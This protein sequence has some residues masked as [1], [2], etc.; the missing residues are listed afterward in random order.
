M[1]DRVSLSQAV[2]MLAG[3]GD[4]VGLPSLSRYVKAHADALDA[5]TEG[6]KILVDFETL[7]RHRAENVFR[8][9]PSPPAPVVSDVGTASRSEEAAG[10]L[11]AQRRLRELELAER[12]K[13]LTPRREV[14]EAA[15]VAVSALKNAFSL[16]LAETAETI[17]AAVGCEARLI[18]PHLRSFERKGLEAFIRTLID[19]GLTTEEEAAAS[20]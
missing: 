15:V 1:Q 12:E 3:V 5:V 19:H 11:R 14:E 6:R 9:A 10:N 2:E 20:E 18:R 17:A 4:V 13:I 16:A 8:P 7:R